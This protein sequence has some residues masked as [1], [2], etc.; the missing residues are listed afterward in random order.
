MKYIKKGQEPSSL[1]LWNTQHSQTIPPW[2]RFQQ[3]VKN[4]VFKNRAI[5]VVIVVLPSIETNAILNTLNP[6]V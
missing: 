3:S 4:D 1:K 6:R 2:K 5:F